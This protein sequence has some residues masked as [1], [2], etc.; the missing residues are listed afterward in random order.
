MPAPGWT[1]PTRPRTDDDWGNVGRGKQDARD[2]AARAAAAREAQRRKDRRRTLAVIGTAVLVSL[3]L[4][5]VVVAVILREIDSQADL[6]AAAN[7][8]VEGVQEY[9]GLERGHV[10]EPV[11]Y[12]QDPPV[13]GNHA[14]VWTNCGVYGEPVS[15]EQSVHSLEHGAV[16]VTYQP[17]LAPDQVE[18]LAQVVEANDYALLSPY[19]GL[20]SPVVAS[21]WGTQLALDDVTDPRL[22]TFLERYLQGE[23]APEPGAPC[24]GGVGGV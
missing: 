16:W 7:A 10:E 2:R 23:E 1:G 13:G 5:A 15:N 19:E 24:T 11:T 20:G 18:V 8:P 22:A 3:V 17:D 6:E 4:V 12:E 14:G 9:P 21:A